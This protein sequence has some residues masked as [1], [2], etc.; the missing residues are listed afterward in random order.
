LKFLEFFVKY[1]I[2]GDVVQRE[3]E[4]KPQQR[5]NIKGQEMINQPEIK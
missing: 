2:G 5:R 4:A 3:G 1:D